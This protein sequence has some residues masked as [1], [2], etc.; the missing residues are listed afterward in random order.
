MGI[1]L[2]SPQSTTTPRVLTLI[3]IRTYDRNFQAEI[4]SPK[5]QF[6]AVVHSKWQI[7]SW[8]YDV[9]IGSFQH[10]IK[11]EAR[12]FFLV[13]GWQVF[14]QYSS[15]AILPIRALTFSIHDA[16]LWCRY[17]MMI[18]QN[19]CQLSHFIIRFLLIL[20]EWRFLMTVETRILSQV[21]YLVITY[22]STLVF[23]LSVMWINKCIKD[24]LSKKYFCRHLNRK[25]VH[26]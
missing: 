21:S 23:I 11:I 19:P 26:N 18:L 22:F 25:L 5:S 1:T 9:I 10:L 14:T 16:I 24:F 4:S 6:E 12:P 8:R 7:V 20:I 2:Q 17:L 15:F 13:R 3:S